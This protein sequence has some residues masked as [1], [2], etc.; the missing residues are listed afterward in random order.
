MIFAG[1]NE[2]MLPKEI[3]KKYNIASP[4]YTSYPTILDWNRKSMNVEEFRAVFEAEERGKN[5]TTSVY[6]HLPFCESLCTFC[7]CHKHITKRHSVEKPYVDTV[8]KEWEMYE[9]M[10]GAPIKVNEIHLGGGTPTFFSAQELER[11]IKPI[12]KNAEQ[13]GLYSVEGHPNHTSK[14][15]LKTLFNLGFKRVSF[16]VQDYSPEVQKA[17]NRIQS[18]DQVK[19]VTNIAR[20]LGYTT[21]SHDLVFGLPKQSLENIIDTVQKTLILKPDSISL[22]SYA[23]VPWVKGTGQRG[24]SEE[25]LP[26]DKTKRKLYEKAKELL[27]NAGYIEIGMDHFALPEEQLAVAMKSG[28]LNRTFMGY[29]ASNTD[30]MIG[31]GASAIS[32]YEFGYAQ[33]EKNIKSYQEKIQNND[34]PVV[35]G[36]IHSPADRSLKRHILNLMCN[37]ETQYCDKSIVNQQV[38]KFNE[39]FI[40]FE[41]DGIIEKRDGKIAITEDGKPFVRN[42]CMTLDPYNNNKMESNRFSKSV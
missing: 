9:Q 33:N 39:E 34:L 20:E 4:R 22:Y 21:I 7:G 5:K 14:E 13:E 19:Q 27:L 29:T 41:K 40:T 8:L 10:N 42:V 15:Q 1:N 32:E 36:H 12:V 31:L 2:N 18:F 17:I 38:N 25:D 28:K 6:I 24:F 37:F 3:I 35:K 23:H 16:G 11:L 26:S 30:R